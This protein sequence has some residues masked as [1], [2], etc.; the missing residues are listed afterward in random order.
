MEWPAWTP[1]ALVGAILAANLWA[2]ALCWWD[3]RAARGA[4][5]RVPERAL[6]APVLLGGPIGLLV[7]MRRFRHKTMKRSFQVKLGAATLAWVAW[8]LALGWLVVAA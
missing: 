6:V 2:F 4:R 8:V 1:Y 5:R 7:G 3:K